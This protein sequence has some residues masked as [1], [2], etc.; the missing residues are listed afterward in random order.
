MRRADKRQFYATCGAV[1]WVWLAIR[2][3]RECDRITQSPLPDTTRAPF[4]RMK[5][6][7]LSEGK[8]DEHGNHRVQSIKIVN[9][10][11]NLCRKNLYLRNDLTD[12]PDEVK[13]E[14]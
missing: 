1:L 5:T 2:L 14:C 12:E 8:Y 10:F 9:S 4:Y 11:N 13:I 7:L 6:E 3:V